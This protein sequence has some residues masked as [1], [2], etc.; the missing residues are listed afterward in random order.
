MVVG[1]MKT[2]QGPRR[3]FSR[4][5]CDSP[6]SRGQVF[7]PQQGL[8][9]AFHQRCSPAVAPLGAEWPVLWYSVV[10]R[11]GLLRSKSQR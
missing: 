5:L 10:F 11:C 6:R 7:Q 4:T 8:V 1:G 2:R 9:I 3:W